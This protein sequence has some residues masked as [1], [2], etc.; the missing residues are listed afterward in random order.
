[1]S[2][3][4]PNITLPR[5]ADVGLVVPCSANSLAKLAT[6]LAD[7]LVTSTLRAWDFTK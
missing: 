1:M 2:I 3:L 7:N 5:W 6:G 4:P